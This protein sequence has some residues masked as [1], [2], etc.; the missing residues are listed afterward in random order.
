[1]QFSENPSF[2][3]NPAI[4][5]GDILLVSKPKEPNVVGL[6]PTERSGCPIALDGFPS[7]LRHDVSL[8]SE[9]FIAETKEVI[10]NK[11]FVAVTDSVEVNIEIIVAKKEKT[12]P[13]LKCVNGNYEENSDDPSLFC[14]ICVVSQILVNLMASY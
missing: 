6:S 13:G 11:C 4:S 8:P 14:W 12:N 7:N 10:Y 9:I 3:E 5:S 2:P 1:M